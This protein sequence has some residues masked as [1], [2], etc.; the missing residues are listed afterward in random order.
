[1][2]P[3]TLRLRNDNVLLR[4]DPV[5][6]RTKSGLL[7]LPANRKR[8]GTQA[9]LAT[10]LAV[11]DGCTIERKVARDRTEELGIRKSPRVEVARLPMAVAPGDRVIVESILSGEALPVTGSGQIRSAR[12]ED[13]EL[14]RIVREE[15][16]QAVVEGV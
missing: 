11:G 16:I 10:V 2:D 5:E 3:A 7:F 12:G 1:M 4:L 8:R 15:E 6:T 9:V 13:Q 14:L